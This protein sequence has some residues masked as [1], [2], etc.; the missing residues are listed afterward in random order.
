MKHTDSTEILLAI[1]DVVKPEEVC[2]KIIE[3]KEQNAKRILIRPVDENSVVVSA[4]YPL[5]L[6]ETIE[7]FN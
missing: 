1:S 3:H 7:Y 2:N 6:Q 5:T 4:E